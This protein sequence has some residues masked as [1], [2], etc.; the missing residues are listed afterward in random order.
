MAL[1]DRFRTQ[2]RHKNPDAGVRLAFVQE[3]P[4]DERELLTEIAREDTDPRVRRAAAA[5]LRDLALEAFEGLGEA[6]SAAA[7]D[8]L[9][10]AKTLAAIAKSAPREAT[11]LRALA[12]I[13]DAHMLGSIA[14]HAE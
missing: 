7:V 10:D 4:L 12:R 3:I 6:E 8:A 1:L 14:R 5:M 9:T 11:A 13:T 2:S